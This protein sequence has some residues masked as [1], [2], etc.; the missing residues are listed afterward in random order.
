MLLLEDKPTLGMQQYENEQEPPALSRESYQELKSQA[1]AF[2]STL[3]RLKAENLASRRTQRLA[4]G[5][6]ESIEQIIEKVE[7][8]LGS[9]PQAIEHH[10]NSS[11]I[12]KR[13]RL[14]LKYIQL[15]YQDIFGHVKEFWESQA[16]EQQKES[17]RKESF[18]R[19][20]M[21]SISD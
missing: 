21:L 11:L 14:L 5:G 10:E 4:D 20:T 9:G 1:L 3:Q 7:S 18:D 16:D 17:T 2:V 8:A 6:I 15:L 13:S 19:S 12:S